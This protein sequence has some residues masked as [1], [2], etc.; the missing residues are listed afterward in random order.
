LSASVVTVERSASIK[1]A[2]AGAGRPRKVSQ[3]A[4]AVSNRSFVVAS[5]GFDIDNPHT[6]ASTASATAAVVALPPKSGGIVVP[7]F[8]TA[9][10]AAR[11]A[12]ALADKSK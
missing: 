11:T 5:Y 4:G 3:S 7:S 10:T 12:A 8:K 1:R 2:V 6:A 9:A